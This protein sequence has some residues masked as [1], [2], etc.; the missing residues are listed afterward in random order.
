MGSADAS[1]TLAIHQ[2]ADE[3]NCGACQHPIPQCTNKASSQYGSTFTSTSLLDNG[4]TD[5]S[6]SLLSASENN[7]DTVTYS[8]PLSIILPTVHQLLLQDDRVGPTFLAL[9]VSGY[10][11]V[12]YQLSIQL[13]ALA[14]GIV[15]FVIYVSIDLIYR[16]QE[17]LFHVLF[18]HSPFNVG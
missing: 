1:V 14:M 9:F 3:L 11:Y 6:T 7:E 4:D 10:V 2:C 13:L 8:Q 15:S 17:Y 16:I 18:L 12:R 5:T